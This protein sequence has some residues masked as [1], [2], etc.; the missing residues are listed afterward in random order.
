MEAKELRIGNWVLAEEKMTEVSDILYA[1]I[2]MDWKLRDVDFYWKDIKGIPLTPELLGKAGFK[3][4]RNSFMASEV[5]RASIRI[6]YHNGNPAECSLFQHGI[7]FP[8][9][10]GQFKY[11]HSLQNLYWCLT[12]E[13]L[14]INL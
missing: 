12:G 6:G 7:E 14:T 8:L 5:L 13:E 2:N 11:L 10:A 9:S 3:M 4:M 1:G